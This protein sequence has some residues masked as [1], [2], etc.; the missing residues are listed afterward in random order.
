M[1]TCQREGGDQRSPG[2]L[3]RRGTTAASRQSTMPGGGTTA[4]NNLGLACAASR[5]R[6]DGL[7]FFEATV[8]LGCTNPATCAVTALARISVDVCR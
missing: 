1:V 2:A 3:A 5:E 4:T 8:S 7:M 6:A